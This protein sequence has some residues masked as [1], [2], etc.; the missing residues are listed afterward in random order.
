IHLNLMIF[1]K[2]IRGFIRTQPS[3]IIILRRKLFGLFLSNG[4]YLKISGFGL[5]MKLC[6]NSMNFKEPIKN[7]FLFD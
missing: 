5:H 4:N 2:I 1:T 3:F 7:G 6:A